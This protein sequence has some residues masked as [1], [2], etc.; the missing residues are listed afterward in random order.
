MKLSELIKRHGDDQIKFQNL[1]TSGIDF[2]YDHKTGTKITFGTDQ[3]LN[4]D[5]T[6]DL[7][8]VVW[9]DREKTKKLMTEPPAPD[10]VQELVEALK[11]AKGEFEYL[12][13]HDVKVDISTIDTLLSK[14]SKERG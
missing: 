9:L 13:L 6:K 10:A 4:L 1:D 12:R 3:P 5:G 11:W 8:L 14:H 7:G 2:K